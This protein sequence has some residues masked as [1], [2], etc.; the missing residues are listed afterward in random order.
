MEYTLY[1][2]QPKIILML[3][4]LKLLMDLCYV[5]VIQKKVKE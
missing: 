1:I 2:H 4:L 3:H 5:M